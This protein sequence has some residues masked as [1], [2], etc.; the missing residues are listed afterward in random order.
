MTI[1]L[2]YFIYKRFCSTNLEMG[3]NELKLYVNSA[4]PIYN[5]VNTYTVAGIQLCTGQ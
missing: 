3:T 5:S 4:P 2:D 1:D